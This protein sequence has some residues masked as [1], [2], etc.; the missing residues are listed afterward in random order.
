MQQWMVPTHQL[1]QVS[2]KARVQHMVGILTAALLFVIAAFL[3]SPLLMGLLYGPVKERALPLIPILIPGAAFRILYLSSS[4]FYF[5]FAKMR[6]IVALSI[7]SL[8]VFISCVT[9]LTMR[10]GVTGTALGVTIGNTFMGLLWFVCYVAAFVAPN[11]G[12]S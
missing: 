3:I 5:R 9:L 2:R 10:Q 4:S 7:I 8:A 11:R 1:D 12:T 6:T